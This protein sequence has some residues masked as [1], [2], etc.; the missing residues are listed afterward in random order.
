MC[1][2]GHDSGPLFEEQP[3]GVIY[4]EGLIE[5]K[6]TL[7]CQ[8][9]ASPAASY[10]CVT[11]THTRLHTHTHT[12]TIQYLYEPKHPQQL[13]YSSSCKTDNIQIFREL[14]SLLLIPLLFVATTQ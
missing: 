6:V 11:C 3:S 10:R 12:P 9:R 14:E 7:S 1:V 13:I 2:S 5:G 8:A 4:P